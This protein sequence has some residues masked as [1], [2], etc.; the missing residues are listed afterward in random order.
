[1][2]DPTAAALRVAV[3]LAR[4]LSL[5]DA[6]VTVPRPGDLV[7]E[8]THWW[9]DPDAIGWLLGHD[10]APYHPG[11]PDDGSVPMREVWDIRPVNPAAALQ[12]FGS[13]PVDAYQAQRWENADFRVVPHQL[14]DVLAWR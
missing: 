11:D 6:I 13:G 10:E 7:V 3:T 1:M 5:L 9:P 8:C 14:A 4:R 2:G 12:T